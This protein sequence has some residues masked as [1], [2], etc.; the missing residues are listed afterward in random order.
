MELFKGMLIYFNGGGGNYCPTS[1]ITDTPCRLSQNIVKTLLLMLLF[2]VAYHLY[3]L[4]IMPLN[5]LSESR[6]WR[7][8]K[9]IN[10]MF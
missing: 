3:I 6:V 2:L 7:G 1:D 8:S 10:R 5:P 4:E 9:E